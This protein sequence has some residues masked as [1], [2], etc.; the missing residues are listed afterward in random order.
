MG[1]RNSNDFNGESQYFFIKWLSVANRYNENDR[2]WA[3]SI[4]GKITQSDTLCLLGFN[5]T[6]VGDTGQLF[7]YHFD[8]SPLEWSP[9][10][11]YG[12]PSDLMLGD[13]NNDG[14]IDLIATAWIFGN[15]S[16]THIC[17]DIP[18]I[19]S[20]TIFLHGDVWT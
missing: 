10:K 12:G 2:K 17:M 16:K 13:I 5:S 11:L 14:N 19:S 15:P 6:I 9:L 1:I 3:R 7:A 18:G 20:D 8:G 4:I